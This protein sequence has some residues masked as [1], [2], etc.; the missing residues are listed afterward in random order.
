MVQRLPSRY[1]RRSSVPSCKLCSIILVSQSVNCAIG[2]GSN[3][4]A[5]QE[6]PKVSHSQFYESTPRTP[7]SFRTGWVKRIR[8]QYEKNEIGSSR[9]YTG[10]K[11]RRKPPRH[12]LHHGD[13]QLFWACEPKRTRNAWRIENPARDLPKCCHHLLLSRLHLR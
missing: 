11:E 13:S 12:R 4:A 10:N 7:N 9:L 6:R 5:I 8:R 2:N 3:G 1:N